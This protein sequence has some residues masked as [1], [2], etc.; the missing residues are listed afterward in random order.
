M[1]TWFDIKRAAIRMN[2]DRKGN[3]QTVDDMLEQVRSLIAQNGYGFTG[4]TPTS[5]GGH[6]F[7]TKDGLKLEYDAAAN[8]WQP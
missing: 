1:V 7:R 4:P 5:T 6:E 3:G 8:T 2:L